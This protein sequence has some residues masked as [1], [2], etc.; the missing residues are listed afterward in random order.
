LSLVVWQ[1]DGEELLFI[2]LMLWN[3]IEFP[4]AACGG[5]LHSSAASLEGLAAFTGANRATGYNELE[6]FGSS[7]VDSD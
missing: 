4:Q 3:P 6:G 2:R 7:A 1:F 5:L